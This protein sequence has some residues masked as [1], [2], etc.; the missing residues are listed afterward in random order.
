MQPYSLVF[1]TALPDTQTGTGEKD[2]PKSLHVF[3]LTTKVDNT[4][5]SLSIVRQRINFMGKQIQ[6]DSLALPAALLEALDVVI[7]YRT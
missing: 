3:R 2:P 5:I 4:S 6:P 7:Q 1:A